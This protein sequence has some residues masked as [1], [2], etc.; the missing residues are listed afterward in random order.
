MNWGRGQHHRPRAGRR[1]EVGVSGGVMSLLFILFGAGVVSWQ[2]SDANQYALFAKVEKKMKQEE[3][4]CDGY[5][6]FNQAILPH[7]SHSYSNNSSQLLDLLDLDSIRCGYEK[8][9]FDSRQNSTL[10]YL[11]MSENYLNTGRLKKHDS[12]RFVHLSYYYGR[13]LARSYA[14]AGVR[15]LEGP[16]APIVV[17]IEPGS[18]TESLLN[19]HTSSKN[20]TNFGRSNLLIVVR[21]AP[22]ENHFI[23]KIEQSWNPSVM[24]HIAWNLLHTYPHK[25]VNNQTTN[26]TS[27]LLAFFQELQSQV[28]VAMEVMKQEP[29]LAMDFQFLLDTNGRLYYM[30]LDRVFQTGSIEYYYCVSMLTLQTLHEWTSYGQ[31]QLQR[32]AVKNET[33]SEIFEQIVSDGVDNPKWERNETDACTDNSARGP[34]HTKA[35]QMRDLEYVLQ[36]Y[37][38]PERDRDRWCRPEAQS[39]FETRLLRDSIASSSH[40][41]EEGLVVDLL[42]R[43]LQTES[44]NFS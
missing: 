2:C 16:S 43:V 26:G 36:H 25:F 18:R 38:F 7:P 24:R 30:D 31:K 34:N 8:C 23:K 22:I 17:E 6:L 42:Q 14:G 41:L 10:G 44:R 20:R 40:S 11:L 28:E 35:E 37:Y 32:G 1:W 12:F 33:M 29:L 39:L 5:Q 9:Y 15:T 19:Q 27:N 4:A 3:E 13:Y 21:R